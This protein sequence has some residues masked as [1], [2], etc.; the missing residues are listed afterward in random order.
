M[1]GLLDT[2]GAVYEL[3]RLAW[4]GRFHRRSSYAT[5]RLETAFG[6]GWP[7]S[8]RELIGALLAYGRW[9]HRM[10]RGR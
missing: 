5:W 3:A 7:G 2:L 1:R 10:R 6:C 9:I 4:I 8:R